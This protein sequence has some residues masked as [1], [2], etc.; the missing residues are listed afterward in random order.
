MSNKKKWRVMSIA[1]FL[2][3]GL[4][5]CLYGI[6]KLNEC[7]WL[8]GLLIKEILERVKNP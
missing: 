4:G 3:V 1:I 6:R 2:L 8:I 5:S 7:S